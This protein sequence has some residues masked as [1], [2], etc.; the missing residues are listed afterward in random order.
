ML[1]IV[2]FIGVDEEWEWVIDETV[3]MAYH[4]ALKRMTFGKN[5]IS[6]QRVGEVFETSDMKVW[7]DEKE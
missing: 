2:H 5:E 1:C 4:C 6:W 3:G 7:E